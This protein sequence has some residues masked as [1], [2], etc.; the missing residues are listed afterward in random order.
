MEYLL[1]N[2][3]DYVGEPNHQRISPRLLGPSSSEWPTPASTLITT[4]ANSHCSVFGGGEILIYSRVDD[5]RLTKLVDFLITNST[6]PS[7]PPPSFIFQHYGDN[8]NESS[9]GSYQ[10]AIMKIFLSIFS[11]LLASQ[12]SSTWQ[13]GE[14]EEK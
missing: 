13:Q 14:E 3:S 6:I 11:L 7:T 12:V 9:P 5:C 10:G 2:P 8:D 4:I 1:H